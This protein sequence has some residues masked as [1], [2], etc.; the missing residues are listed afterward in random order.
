MIIIQQRN[1]V[2]RVF[3]LFMSPSKSKTKWKMCA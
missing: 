3:F 1:N 2:K